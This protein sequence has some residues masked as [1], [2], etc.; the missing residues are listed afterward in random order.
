MYIL[1][2]ALILI[3]IVS[4]YFVSMYLKPIFSVNLPLKIIKLTYVEN[5]GAAF[6]I[7]QNQKL[8]FFLIT[9]LAIGF[10][11]YYF[12]TLP[13]N[14]VNNIIKLALVLIFSGTIGN[15]LD[16]IFRG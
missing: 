14:K 10:T 13:N 4:K 7:L 12:F 5:R 8:F 15:F 1:A 3:D 6:G 16:R 9:I 2:L 11:V